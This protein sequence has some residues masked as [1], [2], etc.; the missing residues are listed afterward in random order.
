MAKKLSHDEWVVRQF[1]NLKTEYRNALL[2]ASFIEGAVC[3]NS[4]ST[5][6]GVYHAIE[7]LHIHGK[8]T[9]DEQTLLHAVRGARNELVHSIIRKEASQEQVEQ[10][11][12]DLMNKVLKA[13]RMSAFLN[14]E[15]F[16]KYSI[17]RNGLTRRE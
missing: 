6:R 2:H 16:A 4:K 11:L 7:W 15:L 8:I 3:N 10:W 5:R 17:P 14:D 9:D 12:D 1:G 13:Y